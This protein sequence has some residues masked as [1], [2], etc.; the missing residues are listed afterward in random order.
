MYTVTVF[1]LFPT[2]QVAVSLFGFGVHWYGILYV[3]AFLVAYLLLP[4][5][6]GRRSLSLSRDDWSSVL[7][8]G[9][10]GVLVGGRLGFV[11][12]YHPLYYV[13]HP[14]EVLFV[15]K[16]GMSSHGGFVGVGLALLLAAR[17][18][19]IPLP[20]L[21]DLVVVPAA[22][23]LALGRIGNFINGEL[24]GTITTVP[25]AIA[26]PGVEGLRHPVQLYAVAKDLAIALLCF[27]HLTATRSLKP[28][29]TFALFL[30]LY[31]VLRFLVEF[32]REP[33]SPLLSFG[34]IALT[35]G[36]AYSL[37]LFLIG[38]VLWVVWRRGARR[39]SFGE[40]K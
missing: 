10:L 16:G 11:L 14:L 19:R 27:W 26:V 39:A 24:Y 7:T 23:G 22:V 21:L 25:W 40:P 3:V 5:L 9:I 2:R 1:T 12:L 29:G 30:V 20:A 32:V 15:W 13:A 35:R 31:S 8:Y 4:R 17:R 37:P 34:G 33:D 38:V 36:Q 28:G 6:Q 18:H